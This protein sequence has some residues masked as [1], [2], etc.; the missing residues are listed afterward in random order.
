MT[1]AGGRG[2]FPIRLVRALLRLYPT[3]FR[4]RYGREVE[5]VVRAAWTD[6]ADGRDTHQKLPVAFWTAITADLVVVA[7]RERLE[8]L[9]EWRHV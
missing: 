8:T 3:G 1:P 5:Q 4:D 7:T 2:R 9:R 6:R